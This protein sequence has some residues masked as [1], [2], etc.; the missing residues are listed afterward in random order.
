MNEYRSLV[1]SARVGRMPRHWLLI[2]AALLA[3]GCATDG[4]RTRTEGAVAGAAIGAAVGQAAGGDSE[5]TAAGAL[6]GAVVGVLVGDQVAKK[7]A[8]YAKREDGLRASAE[9]ARLLAQ[10]LQADNQRLSGEIAAL[11]LKLKQIKARQASAEARR[12]QVLA[13]KQRA[14][15]LLTQVDARLSS[16]RTELAAQNALLESERSRAA[17]AGENAPLAG[18]QLVKDSISELEIQD[19]ALERAKQQLLLIDRRRAY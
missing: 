15:A 8:Q 12:N 9:R 2:L 18:V 17:Q 11:E 13:Q 1:W 19:R 4:L 14:T 10:S 5:A 16:V 7:K 6:A 3:G